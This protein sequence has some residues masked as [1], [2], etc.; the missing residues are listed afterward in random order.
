MPSL[1]RPGDRVRTRR[2]LRAAPT[3]PI[4]TT[5]TIILVFVS[6]PDVY[7]VRFEGYGARIAWGG[8]IELATPPAARLRAA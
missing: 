6:T 4:G 7:L 5:G 8:D 1:F 2:L 3:I